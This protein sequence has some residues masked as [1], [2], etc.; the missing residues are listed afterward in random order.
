MEF[1]DG[2]ELSA[3]DVIAAIAAKQRAAKKISKGSELED[4]IRQLL[5]NDGKWH[6]ASPIMRK[7]RK[8]E[9]S[10]TAI[11]R[12]RA[13]LG[14]YHRRRPG[15]FGAPTEWSWTHPSNP[16]EPATEPTRTDVVSGRSGRSGKNP[17][18]RTKTTTPTKS[19]PMLGA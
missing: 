18:K 10:D 3:N 12:A 6:L 11:T 17:S 14:I 5:P 2:G 7:C 15:V 4:L 9:Y 13:S 8:Q 19:I 1:R 16:A